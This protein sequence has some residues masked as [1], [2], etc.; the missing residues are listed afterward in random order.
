MRIGFT[1]T[2]LLLLFIVLPACQEQ[3]PITLQEEDAIDEPVMVRLQTSPPE[4]SRVQVFKSETTLDVTGLIREDEM[5]Y[6]GLILVM[7]VKSD[8]G[9]GRSRLSY[10]SIMLKNL[11]DTVD[12]KGGFGV[13]RDFRYIDVGRARLDQTEFNVAQ[14]IVQILSLQLINVNVGVVHKLG[15]NIISSA[16]QEVSL[17]STWE[18]TPRHT[19]VVSAEGKNRIGAFALPIQSPDEVTITNIKPQEYVF[20]DEDLIVRWN[21][22][23]GSFVRFIFSSY[24]ETTGRAS[25]PFMVLETQS[26]ARALRIP[27]KLL[28]L[29]PS[30]RNGKHLLSLVS[31]HRTNVSLPGYDY[32]VLLQAASIHNIVISLR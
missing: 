22:E 1:Y 3:N 8:L 20:R 26:K 6:P 12:V 32:G 25:H 21:G 31:A 14:V 16:R 24:D 9:G 30:T 29:I 19:Y 10:S 18:Y 7:G 13:Y 27:S 2:A 11:K 5:Q 17:S 23:P 15:N 28:K 4:T